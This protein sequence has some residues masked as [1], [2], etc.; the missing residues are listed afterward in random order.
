M[1][2]Y[3][4]IVND[5]E[6]E[7]VLFIHGIGGST[8]TWKYQIEK[9]SEKYNILLVDL[10]GHGR[11]KSKKIK[12]NKYLPFLSACNIN[13]ILEKEN[14][15]KVHIVSMSLGT[16]VA[17][18]FMVH[19]SCKVSSIIMS[20]CII[21]LDKKRDLLLKFIQKVKSYVPK[22]FMYVIFANVL[23]PKENH[24]I[25][26][27]FFIKESKKMN[28]YYFRKWIDSIS[29]SKKYIQDYVYKINSG[30][31]VLFIMGNEDYFFF[32]G[33]KKLSTKLNKPTLK[34]MQNCG[35][36]CNL[37]KIDLFNDISLC[38]L[39]KMGVVEV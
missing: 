3:E 36:V 28:G 32:K 7:W 22:H 27:L 13:D 6:N 38:W 16:L 10:E 14:I 21:N 35:H 5:I 11:N 9:Y 20:G 29:E 12:D 15:S 25:S 18:E 19:F 17:L 31:P 2:Y 8:N 37:E 4:K 33:I 30:I 23:L 39:Q 26:R 34:I 1:L 24:K